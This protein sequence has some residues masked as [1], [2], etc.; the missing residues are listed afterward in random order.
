LAY[1]ALGLDLL[2]LVDGEASPDRTGLVCTHVRSSVL[3]LERTAALASRTR[4]R[5]FDTCRAESKRFV[6]L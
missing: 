3:T 5:S 4:V 6:S 1:A 2:D